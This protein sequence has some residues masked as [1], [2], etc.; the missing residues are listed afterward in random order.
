MLLLLWIWLLV[1]IVL[2]LIN[3][4]HKWWLGAEQNFMLL[5][6][7]MYWAGIYVHTYCFLGKSRIFK[8]SWIFIF[9]P[10]AYALLAPYL[11]VQTYFDKRDAQQ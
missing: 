3:C 8:W 10:L 6:I 7:A 9:T 5:F 11:F 2:L 1:S 4:I